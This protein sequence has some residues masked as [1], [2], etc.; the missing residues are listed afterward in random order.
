MVAGGV[1]GGLAG[2]SALAIALVITDGLRSLTE[3]QWLGA[4]AIIGAAVGAIAAPIAGWLLLRH[5]PLGRAFMG[6]TLGTIVGGLI[7]LLTGVGTI[8]GVV[9]AGAVGFLGAAILLRLRAKRHGPDKGA[10]A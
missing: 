4:A 9:G 2:S 6:L 3:F 10:A 8:A 7:G 1:F 5:V